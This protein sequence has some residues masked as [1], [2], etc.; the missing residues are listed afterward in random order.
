MDNGRGDDEDLVVEVR[1]VEGGLSRTEYEEYCALLSLPP[2]ELLSPMAR[3]A[4]LPPW[5]SAE[6]VA[7]EAA[8]IRL[9]AWAAAG[10]PPVTADD[11]CRRCQ[12]IGD[13]KIEDVVRLA[14][15][16]KIAPPVAGFLLDEMLWVGTGWST[17]GWCSQTALSPRVAATGRLQ[18]IAISGRSQDAAA[19]H[20]YVT[21]EAA[22]AW[23]EADVVRPIRP[24]E[25]YN[26]KSSRLLQAA[27]DANKMRTYMQ[28]LQRGEAAADALARRWGGRL[29]CTP[30]RDAAHDRRLAEELHAT[31]GSKVAAALPPSGEK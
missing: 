3:L 24:E 15:L 8:R 29:D 22:H 19:V 30:E 1:V 26:A 18:I 21:H 12:F 23:L 25:I 27:R 31:Y 11:V 7:T 13:D 14:L 4:A 20:D 2:N 17:G 10:S 16:E 9:R 6:L 5:F 28:E